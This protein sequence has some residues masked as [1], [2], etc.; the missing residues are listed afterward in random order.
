MKAGALALIQALS[1]VAL[2]RCV[3]VENTSEGIVISEL[4]RCPRSI[5]TENRN[6]RYHGTALFQQFAQAP[7]L[8]AGFHPI[9][10][11]QNAISL[12]NQGF[13]Y[14]EAAGFAGVIHKPLTRYV[15]LNVG[16][17]AR[18]ANGYQAQ[19]QLC[20]NGGAKNKAYGFRSGDLVDVCRTKGAAQI[21]HERTKD[22][23]VSEQR[24]EVQFSGRC[25]V[26]VLQIVFW[27]QGVAL[28]EKRESNSSDEAP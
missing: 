4:A 5:K 20:R 7:Q 8:T 17:L 19:F 14:L 1:E 9:V 13:V 25:K 16:Q 24:C 22:L 23:G 6:P 21:K 2:V 12:G 18:L 26:D 3:V 11:Q 10:N 15:A 28:R 27:G